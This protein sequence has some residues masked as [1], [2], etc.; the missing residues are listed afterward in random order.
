MLMHMQKSGHQLC[1]HRML[2]ALLGLALLTACSA[3]LVPIS[4]ESQQNKFIAQMDLAGY[5]RDSQVGFD[6]IQ[7]IWQYEQQLVDVQVL[8]PKASTPTPVIIYLPGLGESADAGQVWR[9]TWVKA[10]YTVISFQSRVFAD[11]LHEVESKYPRR[12]DLEDEEDE[13]GRKD[14][15]E[16]FLSGSLLAKAKERP[17]ISG[18]NSELHYLGFQYFALE[19]LQTR[20]DQLRWL[21][22]ELRSARSSGVLA[23]LDLSKIILAG[24]DLGAQTVAAAIG[25]RYEGLKELP[26]GFAPMAAIILSPSVNLAKGHVNSRFQNINL[27]LLVITGA[28]DNDPYAISAASTRQLIW[29]YAASGNKF[30]LTLDRAKHRLFSGWDWGGRSTSRLPDNAGF[31]DESSYINRRRIAGSDQYVGENGSLFAR[32]KSDF[33]ELGYKSVAAIASVSAAFI[34]LQAKNDEFAR[35]WLAEK[36]A[37][38]LKPVAELKVR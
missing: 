14:A 22:G 13:L 15:A 11:A 35:F 34:D 3:Q 36:T 33:Q 5:L 12:G 9:E 1:F 29:Q 27:P 10:G 30:L 20:L 18:R 31:N 6:R 26:L 8:T 23:R 37:H 7:Q 32:S 21:V 17:S 16:N 2:W 28:D 24:Y 38:C 25:E 19:A 4:L